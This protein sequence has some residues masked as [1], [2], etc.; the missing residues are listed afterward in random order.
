MSK[1]IAL[2]FLLGL[3]IAACSEKKQ[4]VEINTHPEVWSNKNSVEFHGKAV[5]ENGTESCQTCHGVDF[6][7]GKSGVACADCHALFPHPNGFKESS[8]PNFHGKTIQALNWKLDECKTCHGTDYAGGSSGVSCL[9]CHT[10]TGGPEACTTCHGNSENFAPPKDLSGNTSHE[11]VG[12]GA[13]Q[14]HVAE[15]EVTNV[16]DCSVC[17]IPVVGFADP[18][19]IDDT[20]HAEVNFNSFATQNGLLSP[21]WSHSNTTCSGVYCHGGFVFKKAES[22]NSWAYAD[23][24]ITGNTT[25]VVWVGEETDEECSFCHGLPPTG[26]T[27]FGMTKESCVLCHPAVVDAEG[28]IID[29]SKHINGQPDLN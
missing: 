12:V 17:H 13:H 20:P 14:K 8:S 7:G 28:Q 22:E 5:L 2:I 10:E 6:S 26:H 19:H 25:P 27:D 9:E 11:A 23:S 24:V 29:K 1:K 21:V 18:N 15:T 16:L 3:F 4:T